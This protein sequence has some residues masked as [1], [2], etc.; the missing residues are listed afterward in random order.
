MTKLECQRFLPHVVD[1]AEG[2]LSASDRG[3]TEAHVAGCPECREALEA[4]RELPPSVRDNPGEPMPDDAFFAGQRHEIMRS[5][6]MVDD[7]L[8]R[9]RQRGRWR[10][11][12]AAMAA[13]VVAA[14][15]VW[16]TVTNQPSTAPPGPT[17]FAHVE[18][19]HLLGGG[20]PMLVSGDPEATD[21]LDDDDRDALED[22]LGTA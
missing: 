19:A 10:T 5:V 21:V 16:S 1:L 7:A 20:N 8:A 15:G 11:G 13:G 6:R 3:P 4:L 17:R 18:L 14:I 9:E 12:L 2:S 22:L